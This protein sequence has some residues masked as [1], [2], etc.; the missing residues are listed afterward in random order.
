MPLYKGETTNDN[1]NSNSTPATNYQI[2][3]KEQCDPG[4]SVVWGGHGEAEVE[5]GADSLR[6]SGKKHS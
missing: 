4:R 5:G 3:F 6:V 2:K 1:G